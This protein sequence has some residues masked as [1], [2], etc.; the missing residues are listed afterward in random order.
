MN[1]E[2]NQIFF[3]VNRIARASPAELPRIFDHL[4]RRKRL[5]ETI[6]HLNPMLADPA[7]RRLAEAALNRLGLDHSV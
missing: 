2:E 6:R 5:S 1:F 3:L 4:R 7:Y